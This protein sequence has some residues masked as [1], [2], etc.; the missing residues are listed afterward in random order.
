MKRIYVVSIIS[1]SLFVYACKP[2]NNNNIQTGKDSTTAAVSSSAPAATATSSEQ[3]STD[4]SRL[5][6]LKKLK[7]Y[8]E[9][10]AKKLLPEELDGLKLADLT[11]NDVFGQA[12][13]GDYAKAQEAPY[14]V[15]VTDCAGEK[16][17][18]KYMMFYIGPM[19]AEDSKPAKGAEN[20]V[21]QKKVDFEGQ[22]AISRHDPVNNINSLVFVK[23]G[24]LF[25]E[26]SAPAGT[27]L[28]QLLAIA[29]K[30]SAK[31]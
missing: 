16:G 4:L 19:A 24:R 1:A 20:V 11:A 9:Q 12:V 14:K 15:S 29:G 5:E 8:T 13:S 18:G 7:P 2:S 27:T 30:L 23:K 28:E 10:E 25:V 6:E 3:P 17:A 26:M 31:L 22:K 21:T